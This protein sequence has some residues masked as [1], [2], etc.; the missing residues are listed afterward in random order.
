MH[1]CGVQSAPKVQNGAKVYFSRCPTTAPHPPAPK[2]P[3]DSRVA[4]LPSTPEKKSRPASS[5]ANQQ[6]FFSLPRHHRHPSIHSRRPEAYHRRQLRRRRLHWISSPS[7]D[8]SSLRYLSPP[9]LAAFNQRHGNP[10]ARVRT[11]AVPSKRST[12]SSPNSCHLRSESSVCR[13]A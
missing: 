2:K 5:P 7:G 1:N 9:T 11:V 8:D 4:P 13:C 12:I 10:E 3:W 6:L